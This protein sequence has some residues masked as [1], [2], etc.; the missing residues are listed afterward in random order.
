MS[1][2]V[3]EHRQFTD[4]IHDVHAYTQRERQIKRATPDAVKPPG[5]LV[6]LEKLLHQL[7]CKN[8]YLRI[9]KTVANHRSDERSIR[10][11]SIWFRYL[12]Y[13]GARR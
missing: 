2:H 10:G 7:N 13:V 3:P 5:G 4:M 9:Y 8:H 6:G 12:S 11:R 1:E